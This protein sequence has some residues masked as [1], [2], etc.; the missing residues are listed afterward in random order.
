MKVIIC[1]SPLDRQF[2]QVLKAKLSKNYNRSEFSMV[3][4]NLLRSKEIKRLYEL[5]GMQSDQLCTNPGVS[6][7][8]VKLG[9]LRVWEMSQFK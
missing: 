2:Q 8:I 4:N 6:E 1:D 7:D 3:Y 5:K 9:L